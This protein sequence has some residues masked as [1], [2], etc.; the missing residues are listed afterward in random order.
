MKAIQTRYKGFF[1][2]SRLEARWAVYFDAMGYSWEYEPEGFVLSDG[3]K[4]LPDFRMRINDSNGESWVFWFEVKHAGAGSGKAE[5]FADDLSA[6]VHWSDGVVIL[7]DGPPERMKLYRQL[8]E[9]YSDTGWWLDG[10]R[11]RPTHDD[12]GNWTLAEAV[13]CGWI[14][15]DIRAVEAARSARFEFGESGASL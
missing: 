6:S 5:L 9:L 10:L 2:R 15:D 11:D 13:D 7:L 8:G 1:F 12:Q 14:G 3:S 4:Y